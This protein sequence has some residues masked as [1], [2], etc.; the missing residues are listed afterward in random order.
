[1]RRTLVLTF[2]VSFGCA[3]AADMVPLD[4][5][6]GLWESSMTYER[7]GAPPI[8]P[9]LLAKLTPEQR[10][11]ME[12]KMKS[13]PSQSQKT[14]VHKHCLKKE[15]L[16]KP[17]SFGSADKSCTETILTSSRSKQEIRVECAIGGMK[18][19]G[20]IRIEALN[21]ENVKG[22]VQMTATDGARTMNVNTSFSAKWIGAACEPK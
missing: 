10:A 19:H 2:A 20:T 7:S 6:T 13:M 8:P 9:D 3:W 12:E 16:E 22:N 14:S 17:L 11:R 21:S 18:Q 15:E 1:M 5:K 4:V